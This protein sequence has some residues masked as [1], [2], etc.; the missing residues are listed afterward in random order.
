MTPKEC[1]DCK[2]AEADAKIADLEQAVAS[3][4]AETQATVKDLTTQ[5]RYQRRLTNIVQNTPGPDR[6]DAAL[7]MLIEADRTALSLKG[8]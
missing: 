3:E 7:V 4:R 6:F 1:R 2:T 8:K 5:L